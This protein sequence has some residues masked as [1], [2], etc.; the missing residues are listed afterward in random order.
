M[1]ATGPMTKNKII[2]AFQQ[3][4]TSNGYWR[5]RQYALVS[6]RKIL[7]LPYDDYTTTMLLNLIIS[8][9]SWLKASAINMLGNTKNET[10]VDIYQKG[11]LMITA[12]G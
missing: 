4:I 6:L 2:H 10:Y 8:E 3:E 7:T 1:P 12:I 11:A 5:Y 9:K